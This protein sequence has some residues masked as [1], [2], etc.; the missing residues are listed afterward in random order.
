MIA[1]S[2]VIEGI[3]KVNIIEEEINPGVMKSKECLIESIASFISPGTELSRAYGLKKGVTYPVR[4]GYCSVGRIIEKGSDLKTVEIGDTV[5]FSGPHASHQIYDMAKSDGGVLY[6][7]DPRLSPNE[8][9]MMM[10]CWIAMNGILTVD[11]KLGDT[12]VIFGMGNLGM[13]LSILYTEM[14]VK[15]IGI[16][17]V[18]HRCEIARSMGLKNVV[19]CAP[20]EQIKTILELTHQKGADIVIDATGMSAAVENAVLSTGRNGH[21]VLL[22]TPRTDHVTNIT[23]ILNAIHMKMLTVHG[24]LNRRFPF[25]EKEGSRISVRRSMDYLT[26]LMLKKTIDVE[27][28]ISH[29]IKPEEIMSA[30]EGLMYH[31]DQYTSVIIRWE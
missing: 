24:A 28:F 2:I 3:Q 10:M 13:I 25:E 7:L 15:V 30:Y 4:P 17:P 31:K 8:G 16:D 21:V 11:V 29:V 6:K 20:E 22:G 5:L 23:P 26:E 14:G 19:H 18:A 1:R 12:V 9:A 27:K